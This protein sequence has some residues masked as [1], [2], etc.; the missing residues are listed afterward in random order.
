[1]ATPG[2]FDWSGFYVGAHGG[3]GFVS[4]AISDGYENGGQA[5]VNHQFGTF[6]LGMEVE[7]GSVDWGPVTE[8]GSI[9]LR[10]GYAFDRFLAYAAGGLAFEDSVGWT[11]GGGVE[12]ALTD[13]WVIGAEYLHADY[14]GG[15]KADIVRSRVNYLLNSGV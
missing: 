13:R 1:M 7:G 3:W 10:G 15:D 2:A 9:R 6:V 14:V 11:V 8:A 12:Y 4:G 5:G